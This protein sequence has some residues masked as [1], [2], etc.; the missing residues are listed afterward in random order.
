MRACINAIRTYT[1]HKQLDIRTSNHLGTKKADKRKSRR[2]VRRTEVVAVP[3]PL[4]C[5]LCGT[6]FAYNIDGCPTCGSKDIYRYP[7]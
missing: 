7:P 2:L 1:A 5:L 4:V 3:L 6:E